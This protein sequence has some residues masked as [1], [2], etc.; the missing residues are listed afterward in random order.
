MS[1]D[2]AS[3]ATSPPDHHAAVADGWI[4]DPYK[5]GA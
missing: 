5:A 1:R 2:G 3:S 4:T